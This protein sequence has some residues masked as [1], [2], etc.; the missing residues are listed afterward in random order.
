MV[1]YKILETL[2][3]LVDEHYSIL[4]GTIKRLVQIPSAIEK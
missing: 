4:R 1:S 2:E 3:R